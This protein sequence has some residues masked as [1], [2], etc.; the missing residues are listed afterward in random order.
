M[1][2]QLWRL[3]GARAAT[4]AEPAQLD[5]GLRLHIEHTMLTSVLMQIGDEQHAYIGAAGCAGCADA[6]CVPGC[7]VELLRRLLRACFDTATL[8]YIPGGLAQRPYQRAALAWPSA[9]A[10]PLTDLSLAPWP[11]ARLLVHWRG[12]RGQIRAAALLA[13]DADGP[14]PALALRAQGWRTWSLPTP[15]LHRYGQRAPLPAAPFLRHCPHAPSLLWPQPSGLDAGKA[16]VVET[17][18]VRPT[19]EA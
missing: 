7:Y 18:V 9:A 13:V 4:L 2:P 6:R 19:T 10:R 5:Q 17:P 8:R 16:T 3:E 1:A 15:L 11:E 12:R 14:D